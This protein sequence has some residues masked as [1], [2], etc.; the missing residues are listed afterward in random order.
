ME[1]TERKKKILRAI[2]DNYIQTAEPVGSKVLANLPGINCSSATIRNEM[3]DLTQMGLLEQPHTS[4]GRIPSPA[5]YRLYVDELMQDYRLSVD[6]TQSLNQALELKMQEVDKVISQV[7]KMVSKMTNLPAV[8]MT[9]AANTPTVQRFDVIMAGAGSFI[10]VVMTNNEVVKNKLIK[11]PLNCTEQ[12]LKLLAAVL[13]ASLTEL[14][15]DH[16]TPELLQRVSRSAGPAAS[17]VPVIVDFTTHVLSEQMK[18]EVFVTGQMKLLGQ[19]EYRDV[20]KA[21]EVL[22]SL[23]G[24]T[25]SNLPATLSA[26]GGT[27]I[28]VGPENIAKEL[29]D[30]SVVMTRF[31]IGD[32]MQG[33]IGVVGPTRMDYAQVTARLSYF[34]ENL[35]RMFSKPELPPSE[36]NE[37][38]DD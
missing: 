3:A 2:V 15:A 23:D 20:D 26:A 34:A 7:S 18:S 1:L 16:F 4:A 30:T 27:Q 11:L 5:G 22:S 35:G 24:E 8:A 37:P 19:P 36:H 12:D 33:L 29:K 6:E 28:L 14:P 13:N 21:Q 31:D 17:L 9:A 32:G 10:L 25:L 38:G